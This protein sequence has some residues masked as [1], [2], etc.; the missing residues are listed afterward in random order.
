MASA[1]IG[2]A[3]QFRFKGETIEMT[4]LVKKLSGLGFVVLGGLTAA[5]GAS[6][7]R[8]WEV[9]IG[10]LLIAIGT[11]VLLAKVVRRNQPS[12]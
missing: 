2:A 7:S 9:S 4:L 1:A 12:S 10:V 5:H 11:L 8:M 6:G 3:S